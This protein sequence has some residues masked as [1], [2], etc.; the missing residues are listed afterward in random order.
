MKIEKH[1][2][3]C[4]EL[5]PIDSD[6]LK[7]WVQISKTTR[8]LWRVRLKKIEGGELDTLDG[9][10][11]LNILAA[12]IRDKAHLHAHYF[13]NVD[14]LDKF[15]RH[16]GDIEFEDGSRLV[17]ALLAYGHHWVRDRDGTE[18]RKQKAGTHG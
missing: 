11:G 15:G 6:T 16:V 1:P 3:P 17:A 13:G 4:T 8:E 2:Y 9:A 5:Y 7:V 12:M 18:H 10:K 14:E